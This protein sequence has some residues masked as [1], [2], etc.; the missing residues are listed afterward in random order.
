MVPLPLPSQNAG[1]NSD[2]YSPWNPTTQA[3]APPRTDGEPIP[4]L[5]EVNPESGS[6]TGGARVWLRGIDFPSLFPLFARFGTAVVPT[7]SLKD[8]PS[9]S[10]LIKFL[11]FLRQQPSGL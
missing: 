11:D 10:H 2:Q 5:T 3:I 8:I 7:V 4:T 9:G 6:I 1:T